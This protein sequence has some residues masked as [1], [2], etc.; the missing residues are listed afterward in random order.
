MHRYGRR[1]EEEG[2]GE[3]ARPEEVFGPQSGGSS[4]GGATRGVCCGN[5]SGV[6][7]RWLGE[8]KRGGKSG[9]QSP[10][11]KGRG[12][13]F[14]WRIAGEDFEKSLGLVGRVGQAIEPE[15]AQ[16]AGP[17]DEPRR[18]TGKDAQGNPGVQVGVGACRPQA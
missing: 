15:R 11:S 18:E 8:T 17:L 6:G 12:S 5:A 2:N 9:D 3:P 14:A 13:E 4:P 10:H 7:R 16:A 1:G